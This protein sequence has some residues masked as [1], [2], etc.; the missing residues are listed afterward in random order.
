MLRWL[1][2]KVK[3]HMVVLGLLFNI[4]TVTASDMRLHH[5]LIL[6]TLTF[7]QGRTVRS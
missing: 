7:I 4:G 5:M 2:S 6:L 1:K 3:L